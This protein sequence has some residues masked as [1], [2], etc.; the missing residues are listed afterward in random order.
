MKRSFPAILIGGPPHSGKSVLVY[1]ITQALRKRNI[2]HYALRACPDGEGDWANE[3]RQDFVR[4]LRIKGEFSSSFTQTV[5]H[6]LKKRHLPLLVDVGGKPKD[7]QKEIFS[8]CTHAVLLIGDQP[9]TYAHNLIHWRQM[10]ATQGVPIIAEIQSTLSAKNYLTAT[11]PLII[12]RQ[13]GLERGSFAAGPVFMALVD[14]IAA[15]FSLDAQCLADIHEKT[16]PA[17]S[18]FIN[19][20]KLGVEMG[21]K[22]GVWQPEEL[23]NILETVP[24]RTAVSVYGRSP[25]WLYT[26]LALNAHPASFTSF[27]AKLGWVYPPTLPTRAVTREDEWEIELQET[28]TCSLLEMNSKSQYLDIAE[29]E[30]IPLLTVPTD[31]GVILSGRIPIW[32]YCA[33]ARQL[34]PTVPWIAIYQP[35]KIKGSIVIYSK[36]TAVSIGSIIPK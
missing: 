18:R 36:E 6:Y 26:A 12:G 35:N 30:K 24:E 14:K 3:I 8:H 7:E 31:K 34:I 23:P 2:S 16:A 5:I 25:I 29:P 32:L 9:D 28:E 1:S 13:Q 4:S 21:N 11:E 20:P 27:D 19:L 17:N 10:M 22:D 15:L 33:V